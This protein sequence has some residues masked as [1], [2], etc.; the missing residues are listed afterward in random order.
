M[1]SV[2]L[3]GRPRVV[4]GA[5]AQ[6]ARK[7]FALLAYLVLGARRSRR[8]LSA[9]LF[10]DADDPLAALRWALADLRRALGGSVTLA[11]DPVR[12][13]V[14]GLDVDVLTV[15]GA[16]WGEVLALPGLASTLLEGFDA[17][18]A[19]EFELWLT[20]E[21]QRLA[22]VAAAVLHEAALA[23][24]ARGRHAEAVE[25]AREVTRLTPYD[26]NAHA[27][28]LRCLVVAGRPAEAR[29]QLRVSTRVI[30][31]ELGV[32]PSPQ[33]ARVV[34]PPE[35]GEPAAASSPA[36]VRGLLEA[37]EAALA[38]GAVAEGLRGVEQAV[39]GARRVGD[40][41]LVIEGLAAHGSALVHAARGSDEE[42]A[43]VLHEALALS[44]GGAVPGWVRSR[45]ER[46]LGYVEFLRGHNRRALR[47]LSRAEAHAED[48]ASRCWV[49]VFTGASLADLG[50]AEA[51]STRLQSALSR[52]ERAGD[53]RAAGYARAFV[54]RAHLLAGDLALAARDL[55]RSLDEMR[56][57]GW[58]TAIPWSLALR[59]ETARRERDLELAA[60]LAEH[61]FAMACQIGDPCWEC[62]GARVL[63]LLESDRGHPDRAVAVLDEARARARRLPDT[64]A[65]AG[66]WVTE[67]RCEV[68]L[69]HGLD[70]A[71]H[72]VRVLE[73]E[74]ARY[75]MVDIRNRAA[76]HAARV[77]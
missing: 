3:L 32:P 36:A 9:L 41:G 33:L 29:D 70:D 37:A 49:D 12:V 2:Q 21:R 55:D 5:G 4:G 60:G 6:P 26:E 31:A 1:P 72:W 75:G 30:E 24:S 28:L 42:G 46:E 66:V 52:A 67:A 40:R 51:A 54:G 77:P 8:E 56:R 25:H 14:D 45:I 11:G 68:A 27:L 57:A 23:S 61:A 18:A 62:L 71:G 43:A 44:D 34:E 69:E 76:S 10:P 7:S 17:G 64:Y 39:A 74:A 16:E 65:W 48:D 35:R 38:A 59:A 20:A 53:L 19:P 73:D 22:G 47:W 50:E 58:T 63:G 13:E 15:H